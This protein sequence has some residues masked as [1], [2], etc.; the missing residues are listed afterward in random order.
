M[1]EVIVAVIRELLTTVAGSVVPLNTKTDE[2]TKWLPVRFRVKL[3][4]NCENTSVVGV[5]ESST[6]AGRALPQ[7]GFRD[8]QAGRTSNRTKSPRR[9]AI[10]KEYVA[11]KKRF[12]D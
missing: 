4:G 10:A 7:S 3:D 1:E 11:L 12:M 8:L 5:T 2:E 6:G 9:V